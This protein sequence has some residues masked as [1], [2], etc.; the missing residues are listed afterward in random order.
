MKM[1]SEVKALWVAALRSGDYKQASGQLK[2]PQG[3]CCL[4]VLCELHKKE[5]P[6]GYDFSNFG[7]TYGLADNESSTG[8]L[9]DCVRAWAEFDEETEVEFNGRKRTLW[10]IN[11]IEEATFPVIA[12]L[13]EAQL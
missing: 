8:L 6:D 4:G 5:Y 12:D 11:D 13:I 2:T 3:H 9:A 7:M 10:V 1:D